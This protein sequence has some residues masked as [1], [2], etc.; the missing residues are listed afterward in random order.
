MQRTLINRALAGRN[1]G[2]AFIVVSRTA[3]STNISSLSLRDL[4]YTEESNSVVAAP[5]SLRPPAG[6]KG[7]RS[8]IYLGLAPQA[9][10]CRAFSALKTCSAGELS[11][12]VACEL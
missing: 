1:E 9:G 8:D 7:L 6:R 11:H 12:F 10:I 3:I 4:G 5:P 2:I